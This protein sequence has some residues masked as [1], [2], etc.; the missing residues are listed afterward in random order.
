MDKVLKEEVHQMIDKCEDIYQLTHVK[1]LLES[2]RRTTSIVHEPAIQ[3]ALPNIKNVQKEIAKLVDEENDIDFLTDIKNEL[4]P[5]FVGNFD[6]L[7]TEDREELLELINE[8]A[9]KDIISHEEFL[10]ATARWRTI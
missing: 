3:Y 1:L 6:N 7:S 2:E 9:D 8:P 4:D 5:E 10:K